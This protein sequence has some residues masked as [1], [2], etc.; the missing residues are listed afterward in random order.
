MRKKSLLPALA[1]V[2]VVGAV[3]VAAIRRDALPPLPDATAGRTDEL[4]LRNQDIALFEARAAADPF[5]AADRARL[6]SLYLQRS[7]E[8]G[9][10]EDYRRAERMARASVALREARNTGALMILS[11]SLLAQHRFAEARAVAEQLVTLNPDKPSAQSLLGEIQL[12][13]GDYQAAARTFNG[14]RMQRYNLAVA[15]RY[16]R[17][18][19]IQGR[20]KEAGELLQRALAEASGR[21]DLPREQVAWF[22]LRAGDFEMRHGNLREAERVLRTGLSLEPGDPRLWGALAQLAA[23]RGDDTKTIAYGEGAGDRAD[24]NTLSV[25]ADAHASLGDVTNAARLHAQIEAGAA[26]Q[27]EPFA[28]QWTQFRLDNER[29]LDATVALLGDEVAQR[30][31]ALGWDM[32]GWGL[33]KVGRLAE[34]RSSLRRAL[35]PGIE[36]A[37]FYFHASVIER[38]LAA[39]DQADRLL[40]RARSINPH[41]VKRLQHREDAV[42][43]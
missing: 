18:R 27:P 16:A 21:G 14:L 40:A 38:A 24:F 22:Y 17:W 15:P 13:L 35:A 32:Y 30:P 41:A 9:D 12:E 43:R 5:S 20:T 10:F 23:L 29:A 34:A 8:T 25:M 33:Y 2:L 37:R 4:Q 28:R 31:D 26:Q 39:D 3:S 36:D 11:S 19:E 6:A 1:G 7:R 42:A